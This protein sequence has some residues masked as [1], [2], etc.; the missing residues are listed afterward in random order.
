VT[1]PV[2][3]EYAL[4][5][6]LPASSLWVVYVCA[7][8]PAEAAGV[9]KGDVIVETNGAPLRLKER[10]LEE[11]FSRAMKP[12]QGKSFTLT[13]LRDSA[14]KTLNGVFEKAPEDET[15]RSQELGLTVKR[16]TDSDFF[17]RN[18]FTR[19]GVLVSEVEQGGPAATS[20]NFRQ[21]LLNPN[22]V[23]VEVGGKP[24]PTFAEF[25]KAIES[26]CNSKPDVLLIK[27]YRGIATGYA[28]LNLKKKNDKGGNQ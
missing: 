17:G 24:T 8:S 23:I 2:N 26:V 25:S 21:R 3:K 7:G 27:Y 13:V 22:D 12:K 1:M 18:M 5:K 20:G 19:E 4:S 14:R 11:Y 16:I 9:R 10:R 6:N 15:L 28:A